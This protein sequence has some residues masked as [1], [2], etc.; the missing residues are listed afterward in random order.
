MRCWFSRPTS[1]L[2]ATLF[3]HKGLWLTTAL[4]AVFVAMSVAGWFAWDSHYHV[5]GC[6]WCCVGLQHHVWESCVEDVQS[7]GDNQE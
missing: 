2:A 1:I 5:A 3:A 7:A 4:Y 6:E